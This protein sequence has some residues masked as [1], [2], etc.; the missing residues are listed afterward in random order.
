MN[1]VIFIALFL[2]LVHEQEKSVVYTCLVSTG[3][4]EISSFVTSG[5]YERLIVETEQV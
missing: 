3:F 4:T 1:N 2:A 5:A